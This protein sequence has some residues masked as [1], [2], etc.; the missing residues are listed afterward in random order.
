[1]NNVGEASTYS[2][3]GGKWLTLTGNQLGNKRKKYERERERE[4]AAVQVGNDYSIEQLYLAGT[5]AKH[6]MSIRC[7]VYHTVSHN[8]SS[9]LLKLLNVRHVLFFFI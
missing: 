8:K 4:T 3:V 7:V 5:T 2:C 6:E 1:M 9:K